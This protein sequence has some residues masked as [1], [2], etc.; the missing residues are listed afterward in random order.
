MHGGKE[1]ARK[2]TSV[3]RGADDAANNADG[4]FSARII[5]IQ[6]SVFRPLDIV[7]LPLLYCPDKN[8]PAAAA[9]KEG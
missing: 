2:R 7:E 1:E 9:E 3:R 8:K 6:H 5:V 4:R